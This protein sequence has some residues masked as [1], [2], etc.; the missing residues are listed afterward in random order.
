MTVKH[1]KEDTM[2]RS[3][4]F[5]ALPEEKLAEIAGV[6]QD[7][8]LPDRTLVFRQGDPGTTFYIIASG[9][10]RVYRKDRDGVETDL[11]V[12]GAGQSFGEMALLTDRPRS[13]NVETL[14]ETRLSV[15]SKEEF[16]RILSDHPQ[17]SLSVIRQMTE[18][19]LRDERKLE[20]E[21]QRHFWLPTLS[22]WDFLLLIG[23]SL[24]KA[25]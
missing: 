13:A 7:H 3:P 12:L 25:R 15:L 18:W 23:L 14:E 1:A 21:A 19:I 16:D 4:V 10:V 17:V 24:L 9:K 20:K 22:G 8:V 11:S 2:V 5:E 6:M